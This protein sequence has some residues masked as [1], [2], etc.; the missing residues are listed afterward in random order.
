MPNPF[1]VRRH[2]AANQSADMS[3]HSKSAY[4]RADLLITLGVVALLALV[5]LPA[6]A[7]QRPRSARVSCVNN[8]RQIGVGFHVWG[9]DHNDLPPH[10]LYVAEGG[11]RLH[12]LASNPWLHYS[13]ISNELATPRLLFCPSDT[14]R[15]AS[16]WSGHPNSGYVHANF[17]NRATSYF[18]SH[19]LGQS[20]WPWTLV[21][22]DRNVG[23]GMPSS[24][25][26]FFSSLS[27]HSS[28]VGWWTNGLHGMM[29]NVLRFDG[30]VLQLSDGSFRQVTS[31]PPPGTPT[32]ALWQ[33]IIP[34]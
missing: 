16:D 22:G 12:D 4:T 1:G 17:R 13:W 14:G 28:G 30:P 6:L 7:N 9:N 19:S 32:A 23:G 2:V 18:L 31:S 10:A 25:S 34:R 11:T 33:F 27:L 5:V 24:D 20:I 3:A 15:P 29:G 21:S 26:V 8:L